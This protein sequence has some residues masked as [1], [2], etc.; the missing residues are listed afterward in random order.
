ML[1]GDVFDLQQ[2][3]STAEDTTGSMQEERRGNAERRD[4]F[5]GQACCR[6]VQPKLAISRR[7]NIKILFVE[8]KPDTFESSMQRRVRGKR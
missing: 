3:N 1:K 4:S 8:E 2:E 5:Y 6:E 7:S